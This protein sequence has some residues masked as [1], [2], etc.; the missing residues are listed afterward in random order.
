MG[1]FL[2]HSIKLCVVA[3]LPCCHV[4]PCRGVWGFVPGEEL[5]LQEGCRAAPFLHL[6][7][8]SSVAGGAGAHNSARPLRGA[9]LGQMGGL[10]P[11]SADG[12]EGRV[13]M[14]KFSD[15]SMYTGGWG[16]ISEKNLRGE[17]FF[18]HTAS[19]MLHTADLSGFSAENPRLS[20]VPLEGHWSGLIFDTE[21][22]RR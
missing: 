12:L 1:V 7:A 22:S 21:L 13:A 17:D 11:P 20:G 3:M 19:S 14:G 9:R 18:L 6:P 2:F 5:T 15:P 16:E 4:S 8:P 10:Y